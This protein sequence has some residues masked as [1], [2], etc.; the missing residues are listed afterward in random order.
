MDND[1]HSMKTIPMQRICE[2]V[3]SLLKTNTQ[4]QRA[5]YHYASVH[6]LQVLQREGLI[7]GF[8]IEGNRINIMLKHYLGSPV[9]QQVTVVSRPSREIF[10]SAS[11]L[12]TKTSFNSG[13]WLVESSVGIMTHRQCIEAG[14]PGK[15]LLGLNT[16][17]QKWV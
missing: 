8:A 7:R 13:T 12:K 11:E 14:V 10:M 4:V 6:V 3:Q 16:G 15:V 17:S 2:L 5:P 9:I 1:R